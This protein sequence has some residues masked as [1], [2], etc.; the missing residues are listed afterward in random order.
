ML[1]HQQK[2]QVLVLVQELVLLQLLQRLL[3]WFLVLVQY[4]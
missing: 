3:L 1:E 4:L 2:L